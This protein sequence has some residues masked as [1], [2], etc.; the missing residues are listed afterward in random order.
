[1]PDTIDQ[2]LWYKIR[3]T[4]I[5][6]VLRGRL[7]SRLDLRRQLEE[8]TLPAEIKQLL[9]RVVKATQLW[10]LEQVDVQQELIAHFND[11]IASGVSTD[12]LIKRFGDERQAA[13]LIRRA[14]R[15]NRP[16]A[17]H[18]LRFAAWS[19][20]VLLV[21]YSSYAIYFFSGRPTPRINYVNVINSPVEKIPVEDRGWTFYRRALLGTNMRQGQNGSLQRLNELTA[22]EHR[23]ELSEFV[24]THQ[25]Q[26]EWIREGSTRSQ[27]GWVIGANGSVNDPELWPNQ[28]PSHV[29]ATG[30]PLSMAAIPPLAG[31]RYLANMLRADAIVAVQ[32][33]DSSRLMEDIDSTLRLSRQIGEDGFLLL[34]LISLSISEI[35]LEEVEYTLREHPGL[36]KKEDWLALSRRLSAPRVAADL[37]S[38]DQERM[39]FDD[40]LQRS[41]TDDGSGN[42]RLTAEG[43]SFS[44]SDD[45]NMQKR[46]WEKAAQPIAG[47]FVP[48]RRKL[49][50]QYTQAMDFAEANLKVATRDASWPEETIWRGDFPVNLFLPSYRRTQWAAERLLGRRDGVVTAIA[51]ELYR[52]ENG[53]Y[54]DSLNALVPALLP[55]VPLDRITGTPI[56]YRIASDRPLLYSVGADRKDDNGRYDLNPRQAGSWI[57]D[58]ENAPE[59][60]WVLYPTTQ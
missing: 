20:A 49:K 52:Q 16:L 43:V 13:Q 25:A 56:H 60:D 11:G 53:S 41:F 48:S 9:H 8:T 22:S 27:L 33:G 15:R 14:K 46:W 58:D 54:P 57:S 28:S 40:M 29:D 51:L 24:R 47:L 19:T 50:E 7:T 55:E 12:E 37:L 26:I 21:F 39:S 32:A 38:F 1:M 10:R 31:L 6:D 17:W 59:G 5:R 18:G 42:G 45:P 44:Q 4:P 30:E 36:I 2:N 35:A 3:H 23:R 34:R